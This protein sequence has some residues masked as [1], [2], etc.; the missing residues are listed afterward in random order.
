MDRE[1]NSH[2]KPVGNH[3]YQS[4]NRVHRNASASDFRRP[5]RRRSRFREP[6]GFAGSAWGGSIRGGLEARSFSRGG[7]DAG[8]NFSVGRRRWI[9]E[10]NVGKGAERYRQSDRMG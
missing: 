7:R 4:E 3:S 6:L 2:W 8:K 1:W 5:Y 10:R 9:A